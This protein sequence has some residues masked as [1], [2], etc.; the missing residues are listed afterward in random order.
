MP[1]L[2][3]G[4]GSEACDRHS[5]VQTRRPPWQSSSAPP[6][7]ELSDRDLR[8]AGMGST[9]EY[10]AAPE[11]ATPLVLVTIPAHNEDRFI[12]SVVLKCR[13][14][15][16]AVL[17]VDDGS[18]DRT[19]EVAEAAGALVV[20]H[21]ANQGKTAA[22]RTAFDR[23]REMSV[24]ALVLLDGD[25]QHDPGNINEVLTPVLEGRA[26]M[27]VG[28]RFAQTRNE[29]PRWRMVGQHAL[30]IATNVGS[31]VRLS[32]TESGFRAFSRRAIEEMRF[33][34]SAFSLEP[35][36]QFEAKRHGWTIAEVPISVHYQIPA[37]RN[38][39]WQGIRTMDAVLR[40]IGAHRPLLFF[41]LP[42]LLIF[43]SGIG[44]GFY[45][46]RAYEATQTLAV[47]LALLTVLLCIIGILSLFVGILLHTLRALFVE[48]SAGS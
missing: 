15:H 29:I 25:S 30:T 7:V 45:V 19:A 33:R 10:A 27:V 6:T 3:A 32:D 26:D 8:I 36:F 23:A 46:V 11:A 35:E 48:Y 37:K 18:T 4:S 17:V 1:D 42:G 20:R 22:V 5:W 9:E 2:P 47:G 44:L 12:G 43:L 34:G 24:D 31:G 16:Q 14:A 41:G 28:S 13:S 39:A 38:V 40:L 21:A